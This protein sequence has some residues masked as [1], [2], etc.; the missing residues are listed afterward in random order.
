MKAT[1]ASPT[2]P[3]VQDNDIVWFST[4]QDNELSAE[5]HLQSTTST[6][7]LPSS[8]FSCYN[9]QACD[10]YHGISFD[11]PSLETCD[12]NTI[13]FPSSIF[14]TGDEC[15]V[16]N[17]DENP[18]VLRY[19]GVSTF[20]SRAGSIAPS[21]SSGIASSSSS[22]SVT[23]LATITH[24]CEFPTYSRPI[25]NNKHSTI[26][27]PQNQNPPRQVL[28]STSV[29][30]SPYTPP[31]I[32]SM[33]PRTAPESPKSALMRWQPIVPKPTSS[34]GVCRIDSSS[35]SG[36][37]RPA[38]RVEQFTRLDDCL[39]GV[40]S[41]GLNGL[42]H[43]TTRQKR[44]R[45]PKACLKC[46]FD[47]KACDGGRPCNRCLGILGN[48]QSHKTVHWKHCID[49]DIL[50][51]SP[52]Q[53]VLSGLASFSCSGG[54]QLWEPCVELNDHP[55]NSL[56]LAHVLDF[57]QSG[58]SV[59][60]FERAKRMYFRKLQTRPLRI[61]LQ[62]SSEIKKF[63]LFR[64]AAA[65]ALLNDTKALLTAEKTRG[66]TLNKRNLFENLA[67]IYSLSTYFSCPDCL[68]TPSGYPWMTNDTIIC[69][70][71]KVES[72]HTALV[73]VFPHR[74][75]VH[76]IRSY[77]TETFNQGRDFRAFEHL[78]SFSWHWMH[79]FTTSLLS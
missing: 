12:P 9:D 7:E 32:T 60:N 38:S 23:N 55:R 75:E 39:I 17:Q 6:D 77:R 46:Q 27:Q 69:T 59:A 4:E 48:I 28:S 35:L 67:I 36:H 3:M 8:V 56:F 68:T 14:S 24:S 29:L 30:P 71:N 44:Q 64:C 2:C 78:A 16:D 47:R 33:P 73:E 58:G 65:E 76:W 70:N 22:S 15:P 74:I 41:S 45:T 21:F 49:S 10:I 18:T 34:L 79:R 50:D 63:V 42:N 66:A 43:Y 5:A 54:E 52:L 25:N 20:D 1:G 26:R 31:I 62:D 53:G 61:H 19:E 72:E 11:I 40:F 13:P 37:K 57:M 51:N